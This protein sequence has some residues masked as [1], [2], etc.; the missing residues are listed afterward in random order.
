MDAVEM[1]SAPSKQAYSEH[2]VSVSS[3][4]FLGIFVSTKYT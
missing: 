1:Q 4:F 2:V 3:L